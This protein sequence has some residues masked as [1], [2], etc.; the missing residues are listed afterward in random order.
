MIEN[1]KNQYIIN[2]EQMEALLSL[3]MDGM[4]TEDE[5][6]WIERHL[7]TCPAC[8]QSHDEL[9]EVTN[10]LKDLPQQEVPEEFDLR[11]RNA[12]LQERPVDKRDVSNYPGKKNRANLRVAVSIAAIFMVGLLSFMSIDQLNILQNNGTDQARDGQIVKENQRKQEDTAVADHSQVEE[13]KAL[14][15]ASDLIHLTRTK[16]SGVVE[17]GNNGEYDGIADSG[18]GGDFNNRSGSIDDLKV[19]GDMDG[20]NMVSNQPL[21]A[22]ETVPVP[23]QPQP[24]LMSAAP[25]KQDSKSVP[26]GDKKEYDDYLALIQKE[27]EGKNYKVKAYEK[28]NNGDWQFKVFILN[29]N[30]D[31]IVEKEILIL[32][33]G[34]M[35]TIWENE[36]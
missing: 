21:L 28:K 22:D 8:K 33:Q 1:K 15:I 30:D 17:R 29:K 23:N 25:E 13:E 3:Y 18:S 5:N 11:L 7:E 6:F 35:I 2:C 27:L 4:T 9:L 36:S 16:Q 32:G 26:V 19:A 34:G 20:G 10:L 12:L 31:N 14:E 24:V